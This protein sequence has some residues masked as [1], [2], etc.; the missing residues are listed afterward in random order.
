VGA[1]L[2][3]L[4]SWWVEPTDGGDTYRELVRGARLIAVVGLNL[5]CCGV[6]V[7]HIADPSARDSG[8]WLCAALVVWALMRLATRRRQTPWMLA[9]L[10]VV[11]A[12]LTQAPYLTPD[13]AFQLAGSVVLTLALPAVTAFAIGFPTRWSLLCTLCIQIAWGIGVVRIP[14]A[15]APWLVYLLDILFVEWL[16]ATLCRWLL[17]RAAVVT[18]D[19]MVRAAKEEVA[20]SVA[21]ARHRTARRHCALMHDTAASTLLMVGQGA[22]ADRGELSRQIGR[23]LDAIESFTNESSGERRDVVPLLQPMIRGIGT[24]VELTGEPELQLDADVADAVLGAVYEAL[25]NIDRHA[26]ATRAVVTVTRQTVSVADDGIGFSVDAEPLSRRFGVRNSILGRMEDVEGR[27]AIESEPGAGTTVVLAWGDMSG[28][29][30]T[31]L[32]KGVHITR[33]LQAMFGYGLSALAIGE[34]LL[35][36]PRCIW[37]DTAHRWGEVL[38]VGV[39]VGLG[40]LAAVSVR[41]PISSTLLWSACAVAMAITPLQQWML[42]N[43]ELRTSA[44]WTVWAIG[45]V[46]VALTYRQPRWQAFS[47]LGVYW[48]VGSVA[49]MMQD[50][51]SGGVVI[52]L[53]LLVS[54]GVVPAAALM[55]T[56]Y[57]AKVAANA[58]RLQDDHVRRVSRE[59]AARATAEDLAER[60]DQ[61][62]VSLVPLLKRLQDPEIDIDD[63]RIRM[64]AM[65]EDARLRRLFAESDNAGNGLLT[66]LRPLIERAERRGVAVTVD[67]ASELPSVPDAVRDRLLAVASTA[68]ADATS[69]GRVIFNGSA[70]QIGISVVSDCSA[71]ARAA[72]ES[73]DGATSQLV[74]DL[75]WVELTVD[76]PTERRLAVVG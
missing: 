26:K 46:I 40:V 39:A 68:L 21:V 11:A 72:L 34:V 67:S 3:G 4:D 28:A 49:L 60:F 66:A 63:P 29:V 25:T 38:L 58:Q 7:V 5:V 15:P 20:S 31:D 76:L 53:Y 10:A 33:K 69:R 30:G 23:D 2:R 18:D 74:G 71:N 14:G 9:D 27:A 59:I 35:Q 1:G 42:P 50:S 22:V 55:L 32:S 24:P 62:S 65:I 70:E 16:L 41:R 54:V 45:L 52:P 57:L 19:M 51:S 17:I 13:S 36:C 6:G 44:N 64:A 56:H 8:R 37:V 43:P 75:V 12:M 47:A 48:I 61:I 73:L